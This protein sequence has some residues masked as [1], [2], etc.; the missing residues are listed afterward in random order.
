MPNLGAIRQ[1][2]DYGS[3]STTQNL[4]ATAGTSSRDVGMSADGKYQFVV[5]STN[6]VKYST[7]FGVSWNTS[8]G[9]SGTINRLAVSST[10]QYVS[11]AVPA[12]LPYI[13]SNYGVSFI[14]SGFLLIGSS[15]D[16]TDICMSSNG[17]FQ[18]SV[19][20][21]AINVSQN[22]GKSWV[23]G[24]TVD[25]LY[26]PTLNTIAC[27]STAGYICVGGNVGRQY[28]TFDTVTDARKLAAGTNVTLSNDGMG[29][30]TIN[31]TVAVNYQHVGSKATMVSGT[32][33]ALPTM[34]LQNYDYYFNFEIANA[35]Y[36]LYTNISFNN[37]TNPFNY[38]S[39][40]HPTTQTGGSGYNHYNG[41]TQASD[42][43]A[44]CPF[45]FS[46]NNGSFYFANCNLTF[47]MSGFSNYITLMSQVGE[48]V[49][50]H[51]TGTEGSTPYYQGKGTGGTETNG[52]GADY[53]S[54]FGQINIKTIR[55][56]LPDNN[57]TW[58]PTSIKISN[59]Q[60]YGTWGCKMNISR[61]AKNINAF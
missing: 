33:Y 28:N 51:G 30:Y 6:Q 17:Q 36:N 55:I 57:V 29:T 46:P 39:E 19:Y 54:I 26:F 32:N 37:V 13:S 7:N 10:G 22:Y 18:L 49:Y 47:K 58:A 31:S 50:F 4:S 24:F 41:A 20:G 3:T 23:T 61:V 16:A 12:N 53:R 8:S 56:W 45:F 14:A 40:Y 60:T 1:S 48:P 59:S 42:S 2:N 25:P 5:L 27:S 35:Y 15:G 21:D 34:D 11:L 44:L 9:T 52:T 38:N 43:G